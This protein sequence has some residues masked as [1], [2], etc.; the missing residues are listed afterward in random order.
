MIQAILFDMGGTLIEFNP[1]QLPWLEWERAGVRAVGAFLGQRHTFSL[2]LFARTVMDA[3]PQ[4]WQQAAQGR[5]N[6][7]LQD[8]LDEACQV[9]GIAPSADEM[10]QA[11]AHYIAPL[12]RRVY[13]Y[14]DAGET[15]RS[16]RRMG[17]VLALVSNTMWPGQYHQSELQ[18]FGLLPHLDYLIFS[19]D[20][21]LWKPQTAIYELALARLNVSAGEALFVGDMPEHD[22]VG[23]HAVGMR[24]VFKRSPA[25]ALNGFKPDVEIGSLHELIAVVN[26]LNG[27]E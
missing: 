18:R 21:G 23:A 5:R 3:L 2:D 25:F 16:L 6:L 20:V 8:L 27:L 17:I 10:E 14:P 12:D 15:L 19:G 26:R 4:R 13:A 7:T 1:D 11:I 22:L 9:C 24:T